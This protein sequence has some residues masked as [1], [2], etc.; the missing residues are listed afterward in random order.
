MGE[1]IDLP[2]IP[3]FIAD[4]PDTGRPVISSFRSKIIHRLNAVIKRGLE[5]KPFKPLSSD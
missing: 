5:Y 1:L 2:L 3:Q 4:V